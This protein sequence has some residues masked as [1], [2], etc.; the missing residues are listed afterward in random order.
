[1]GTGPGPGAA[2]EVQGK[3]FKSV[4]PAAMLKKGAKIYNINACARRAY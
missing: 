2:V 3:Y 4:R 1:M